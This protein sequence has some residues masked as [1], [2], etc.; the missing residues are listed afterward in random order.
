[1]VTRLSQ[2]CF[3]WQYA[4]IFESFAVSRGFTAKDVRRVLGLSESGADMP[5]ELDGNQLV[6]MLDYALRIADP[7]LPLSVQLLEHTPLTSHGTL[8]IVVMTSPDLRTALDAALRFYPLVMPACEIVRQDRGALVHLDFRLLY[9]FGVHANT[10][11]EMLQ[12]VFHSIM[13]HVPNGVDRMQLHFVHTAAFAHET[14]AA[15]ADPARIQ[16]GQLYNRL[17]LHKESLALSLATSSRTTMQI[18]AAQLEKQVQDRL[19]QAE[20]SRTVRAMIKRELTA[21]R[22]HGV[23]EIAN[24]LHIS[25]RTLGRRLADEEQTFRALVNEVRLEHAEQLLR[26]THKPI[27]LI[28]RAAGFTNDSSF[29][30]AFSQRTGVS[31]SAFRA[32]L[33]D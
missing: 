8:G 18:F 3:P 5:S 10:L 1:M 4:D 9:D 24:C 33:D 28:A 27:S 11:M 15:L 32:R 31:P 20:F 16:F 14:Y 21:G 7:A 30:R 12:G 6:R 23:E 25:S 26:E 2:L 13:N 22:L 19:Q 29:A 17:V